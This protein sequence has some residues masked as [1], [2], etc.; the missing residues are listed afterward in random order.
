[1]SEKAYQQLT[2]KQIETLIAHDASGRVAHA[3]DARAFPREELRGLTSPP[4]LVF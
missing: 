2:D 4:P 1:M 3:D